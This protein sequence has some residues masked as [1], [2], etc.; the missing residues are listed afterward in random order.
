LT[1]PDVRL[2]R[3]EPGR[4]ITD[5]LRRLCGRIIE[6]VAP[7]LIPNGVTKWLFNF[8]AAAANRAVISS[9]EMPR[10]PA[11]RLTV[12]SPLRV[13]VSKPNA[14][15]SNRIA[16]LMVMS[17]KPWS[18]LSSIVGNIDIPEN[19]ETPAPVPEPVPMLE[20]ELTAP[21]PRVP[22]ATVD[23]VN[24]NNGGCGTGDDTEEFDAE[25][26]G[27][28]NGDDCSDKGGILIP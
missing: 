4:A 27:G 12:Q 22:V 5:G 21:P 14:T 28:D 9:T 13:V 10:E 15:G 6:A 2:L 26:D 19:N 23:E 25:D 18:E 8:D 24:T 11:T 1:D 20:P 17:S 7:I 3:I 16:G